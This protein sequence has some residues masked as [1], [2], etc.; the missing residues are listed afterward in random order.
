MKK[1]L[2][3]IVASSLAL[4]STAM[5]ASATENAFGIESNSTVGAGLDL[6]IKGTSGLYGDYADEAGALNIAV[7][8]LS[9]EAGITAQAKL[10]MRAVAEKW[11]EY[12]QAGTD[13]LVNGA[14]LSAEAA[15]AAVLANVSLADST[16][17][18]KIK[19]DSAVTNGLGDNVLIWSTAAGSLFEQDGEIVVTEESGAEVV[20]PSVSP[21][22]E[23]SVSPGVEP[24][25]D[26]S[27]I[28]E[29]SKNV[30]TV[31]MKVK[32]TNEE[33]DSYFNSDALGEISVVINNSKVTG[34][35][36]PYAIKAEFDGNVL[37][38]VPG[39]END[40]TIVLDEEDTCY[41]KL[42]KRS[43]SGGGGGG[44]VKP[45]ATPTAEPTETPSAEPTET[46]STEP[47]ETPSVEPQKG[48]TANGAKL[49]Y[50]EKFAYIQG[51]DEE[52]GSSSVRPENNITRAEVAMIFYRLLTAESRE[53]FESN[54]NPFTDVNAEDWFNT[55]IST[56]TAAGIINGYD[57]G[58]VRPNNAITRAEFTAIV[59]R[60][61]SL[62][63]E[64]DNKFNDTDSHWAKE[65]IN[66]VA[67][68]GWI[69]G[70]EDG[71]FGPEKYITRAEAVTII[72]R[73]LYRT[74]EPAEN[75]SKWNDNANS[76]W[77]YDDMEA[78]SGTD[79]YT[80][81]E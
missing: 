67:M 29:S 10:D 77:Y 40:M 37:I 39:D 35:G 16:F 47:T 60:F 38:D 58:T 19:T 15:R 78:A 5:L 64:G 73:L 24:Q 48:G 63:Y 45:T 25:S 2:S 66:N 12:V 57:D 33:L 22:V 75:N 81:S 68:T 7:S 21:G 23:P 17:T 50:E 43:S 74:I 49:N 6:K 31:N 46:P 70:Y 51:Y 59:S 20:E 76:K 71:S 32:A 53:K 9:P 52:D 62:V 56:A 42:S 34:I 80:T 44:I 4:S 27:A 30:Y 14:G 36:G 69:N 54:E 28:A 55:A 3:M 79:N 11:N 41:V 61:T 65:A 1:L 8:A 26:E 72:N 13:A 18:L